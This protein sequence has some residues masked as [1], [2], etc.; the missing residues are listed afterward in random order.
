M[1]SVLAFRRRSSGAPD[2]AEERALLDRCRAGDREAMGVVL[3]EHGPALELHIA[4]LIGPC[5][6]VEDVLQLVFIAAIKAFPRFRGEARVKT[7]LTR[8]ATHV[9]ID[10]LRSPARKRR[11]RHAYDFDAQ[12]SGEAPP[13]E[14]SRARQELGRLHGL[15]DEL[16]PVRRV[17]F[18][19]FAVEGRSIAEV[20]ALT[21]SSKMATKSR[22]FW[23]R[24]KLMGLARRDPVLA[25][26]FEVES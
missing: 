15:L 10:A 25:A 22:I 14:H 13:D 16:T 9:A 24:R 5:P 20:A 2:P 4:R 17:A 19:L 3:A 21:D 23:A 1:G 7:W 12:P 26:R 8:I 11:H 6:D 18:V